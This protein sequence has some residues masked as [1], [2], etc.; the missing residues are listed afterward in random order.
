VFQ[1]QRGIKTVCDLIVTSKTKVIGFGAE[2]KIKEYLPYAYKHIFD[3][4]H[5]N[6]VSFELIT[7]RNKIPVVKDHVKTKSFQKAFQTCVEI[8]VWEDKTVLFFWKDRLEAI[9]IQDN[10]IANSFR[11]YHKI[12]WEKL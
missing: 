4:A 3:K 1:G 9:V 11:N 2:G 12:F 5:K 7:L 10:D 6:N 8:N